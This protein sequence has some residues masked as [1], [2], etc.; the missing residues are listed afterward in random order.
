[1]QQEGRV[2]SVVSNL[3]V[4]FPFCSFLF[5]LFLFVFHQVMDNVSIYFD[6]VPRNNIYKLNKKLDFG[7]DGVQRDLGT[8]ASSMDEWE[9]KIADELQ[10]TKHEIEAIKA[11]FPGNLPLQT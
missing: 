6:T 7:H 2:W 5:V 10:L 9:G 3:F 8:I 1:M 11:K 4:F